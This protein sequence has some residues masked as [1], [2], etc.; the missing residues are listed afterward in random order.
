[1]TTI[2]DDLSIAE[3]RDDFATVLG[4]KTTSR[5]RTFLIR[6]ILWGRQMLKEGDICQKAKKRALEIA[7]E[8]NLLARSCKSRKRSSKSK[9][10]T[11]DFPYSRDP[12]LPIPGAIVTRQ[13][14]GREIRVMVLEQGFEFEGERF[15]SL[16]AIAR[17]VTKTRW[18]GF[19]FFNLG[20]RS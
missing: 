15:P 17:K 14:Q 18:N 10:K 12:R 5:S 11:V 16:S 2:F 6:K 1:M 8:R 3:L 9:S 20:S 19:G 7:D 4:Y 13:Y